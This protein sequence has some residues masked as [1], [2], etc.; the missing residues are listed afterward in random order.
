MCPI[1]KAEGFSVE[2]TAHIMDFTQV[3]VKVMLH[4]AR[5]QLARRLEANPD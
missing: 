3:H 5:A 2:H 4:R 1:D